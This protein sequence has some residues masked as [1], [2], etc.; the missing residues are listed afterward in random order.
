MSRSA[1]IAIGAAFLLAGGSAASAQ[2]LQSPAAAASLVSALNAGHLDAIAAQDPAAA[3][4]FVAA[5][6][7]PG[8]QLLV[9]SGAH[10]TPELLQGRLA[11]RE[12]RDLYID[13]QSTPSATG[14]F[15]VQDFRADGL[16]D[17]QRGEPFDIVSENGTTQTSFN[18]DWKAQQL[19]E[20]EYRSRLAAADQRYTGMLTLLA[21]ALRQAPQGAPGTGQQ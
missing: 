2:E 6:F 14:R 21:N 17:A 5:L 15:F 7:I 10:P 1:L 3:D 4:R 9:V 13:L 8:T 20:E 16:H 12:Y 19:S 11:R 18:G